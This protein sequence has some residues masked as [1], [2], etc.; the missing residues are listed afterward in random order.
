M[1]M[2]RSVSE[3]V[4]TN[5][6]YVIDVKKL[7]AFPVEL[8]DRAEVKAEHKGSVNVDVRVQETIRCRACLILMFPLNIMSCALFEKYG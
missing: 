5:E 3:N 4:V 1:I 6:K 7:Q 8:A 2:E